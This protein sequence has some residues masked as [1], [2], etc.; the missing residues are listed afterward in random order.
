M[1][2]VDLID[3][4][5]LAPAYA[6]L[7]YPCALMLMR[8]IRAR[9][10]RISA[11]PHWAITVVIPVHNGARMVAARVANLLE[12]DYPKHL[13]T[14]LIVDDGSTDGTAEAVPVQ[15]PGVRVLRVERQQGRAHAHLLARTE[16]TGDIIVFTDVDTSFSP[17]TLRALSDVFD[18]PQVSCA[19]GVLQ[20]QNV[21]NSGVSQSMGMYWR[22]EMWL[23]RME[24]DR[25]LLGVAS[26]ACMAVRASEFPGLR[27]TEDI[28]CVAPLEAALGGRRVVQVEDAVAWDRTSETDGGEVRGRIRMV[29]LDFPAVLRRL[30]PRALAIAPFAAWAVASHKLARWL[31]A[32]FLF[33]HAGLSVAAPGGRAVAVVAYAIGGVGIAIGAFA[34]RAEIRVPIASQAYAF[35]IAQVGFTLGILRGIVGPRI[36]GYAAAEQEPV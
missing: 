34:S 6:Y 15:A 22:F 18:D 5:L 26:G 23:R 28:D 19:S 31:T 20:W 14:V 21:G 2:G 36:E 12:S 32:P 4:L 25:G 7:L 17:D 35:F 16:V 10:E 24:S 29:A 27:A 11:A 30:T 3:S 33:L 8:P 13:L 9:Q 1:T